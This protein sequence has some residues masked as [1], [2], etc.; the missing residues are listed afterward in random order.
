MKSRNN[1]WLSSNQLKR[2][3]INKPLSQ[4]RRS[5]TGTKRTLWWRIGW[6]TRLRK[7][8]RSCTWIDCR[9]SRKLFWSKHDST[10]LRNVALFNQLSQRSKDGEKSTGIIGNYCRPCKLR[11]RYNLWAN[12]CLAPETHSVRPLFW[13]RGTEV[14]PIKGLRVQSSK[15]IATIC[16]QS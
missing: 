12:R 9:E 14:T 4:N 16:P 13:R 8:T 3:L 11:K 5:T 7:S 15:L 2:P 6:M 10:S 1:Q